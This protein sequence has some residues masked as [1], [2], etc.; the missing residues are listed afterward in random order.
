MDNI[1]HIHFDEKDTKLGVLNFCA[2][3]SRQKKGKIPLTR[4]F[5]GEVE[6]SD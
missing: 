5:L 2:R 1:W 6:L 4:N 3:P